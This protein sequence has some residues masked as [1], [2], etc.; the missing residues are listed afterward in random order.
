MVCALQMKYAGTTLGE[1]LTGVCMSAGLPI[2][3]DSLP[4]LSLAVAQPW[5]LLRVEVLTQLEHAAKG[6]P[7][8]LKKLQRVFNHVTNNSGSVIAERSIRQ[9]ADE[10]LNSEARM[11]AKMLAMDPRSTYAAAGLRMV[12][13]FDREALQAAGQE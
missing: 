6:S 2:D 13:A 5:V 12:K 10:G 11:L 4:E 7:E 8:L 3:A 9:L 1:H